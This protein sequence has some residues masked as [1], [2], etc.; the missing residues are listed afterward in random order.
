[1]ATTTKLLTAEEFWELASSR[2]CELIDG[3]VVEM[4]PPG[5][6]HGRE[7][8]RVGRVLFRAEDAGVGYVLGEVGFIVRRNPDVVRAPDVAFIR[9]E[10]VPATGIPKAFWEGAPDLVVEIIS[11]SDRPG[12]MQ[13]KIR[14][15]IEAGA[16]QVWA[17]Y[18]DRQTVQVVRSLQDRVTLNADDIL[19]GGDAVPGFS[20]RVA[21]LFD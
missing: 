3:V 15:W 14:E 2:W 16:R 19:D 21:E 20:C 13:T 1:M 4:S 10:R 11:P 7:Q 18:L 5:G 6:E 12:E 9:K 8:M 17:V